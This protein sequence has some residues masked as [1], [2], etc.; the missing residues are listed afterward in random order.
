MKN[1][2]DYFETLDGFEFAKWFTRTERVWEPLGLIKPELDDWADARTPSRFS[3]PAGVHATG[4]VWIGEGTTFEPG[5]F[6]KGPV[7]IG[8]KC[9]IRHNAYLREYSVI[10]DNC[11]V[12]NSTEIKNSILLGH[13]EVPHFNYVG[14][15]ILGWKAHLGA[16]V[17]LSNFK[18]TSGTVSVTVGDEKIDTGLRKLGA[19]IGDGATAG[20]NTVLNPGSLIGPGSVLYPNCNW[21][22]VLGPRQIVKVRHT[23]EVV[24]MR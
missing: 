7:W 17:I 13:C 15:S 19:I 9:R 23:L 16:G 1:W 3:L 4:P 8:R 5:V 21:R 6:I 14:D 11:V 22:G 12:G 2:N 24:P 18:Q 20:C 10:G